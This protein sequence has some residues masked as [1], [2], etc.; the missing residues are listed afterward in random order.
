MDFANRL[1]P[2]IDI[3]KPEGSIIFNALISEETQK[4]NVN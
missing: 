3:G 2:N 4:T 1:L